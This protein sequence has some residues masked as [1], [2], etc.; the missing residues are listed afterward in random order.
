[1]AGTMAKVRRRSWKTGEAVKTAW[2]ADYL[3]QAGK[4]HLKTFATR[5]AADAWLVGTR[6]EI[7]QGVH[8][9]TSDSI[10][11]G[12]AGDLSWRTSISPSCWHCSIALLTEC[13]LMIRLS[14][15]RGVSSFPLALAA[16]FQVSEHQEIDELHRRDGQRA[17]HRA[18]DQLAGQHDEGRCFDGH[19]GTPHLSVSSQSVSGT[20]GMRTLTESLP[21]SRLA[22]LKAAARPA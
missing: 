11:V 3:D 17:P 10:T 15:R 22:R 18:F 21:W 19:A 16:M 20:G 2:V 14:W 9:P 7:S 12:E 6:H 8:T 4:R 1:M 5:K 13:E